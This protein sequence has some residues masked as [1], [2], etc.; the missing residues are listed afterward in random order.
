MIFENLINTFRK[1]M[2]NGHKVHFL[3]LYNGVKVECYDEIVSIEDNDCVVFKATLMQILAMK[4]ERN[5]YFVQDNYFSKNIK[6][7][8]VDINIP[9]LTVTL[10]N[11]V[12]VDHLHANLRRY[13]RVYPSKY[14]KVVLTDGQSEILGNLY[15]ISEG[16]IGVVSAQYSSLQT[17]SPIRA[18]FNLATPNGDEPVDIELKLIA[19]LA[20]RGAVRYCCEIAPNQPAKE[21]ITKFTSERVEETL[22]ELKEQIKLYQ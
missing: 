19:E 14:T 15:D 10:R 18:K 22:A 13:Q 9:E 16:G 7:E 11:F 2:D 12:Y 4:D 20:Y 8:I 6:A 21:A 5:A 1:A 17:G 3:N